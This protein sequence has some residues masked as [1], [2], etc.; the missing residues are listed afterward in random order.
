MIPRYSTR[1]A[2]TWQIV[3]G[4]YALFFGWK[5]SPGKDYGLT[6]GA[7]GHQNWEKSLHPTRWVIY[8]KGGNIGH[9]SPVPLPCGKYVNRKLWRPLLVK[10]TATCLNKYWVQASF[11][12]KKSVFPCSHLACIRLVAFFYRAKHSHDATIPLTASTR[13]HK[14]LRQW[15]THLDGQLILRQSH[16]QHAY[17]TF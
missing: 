14:S 6:S 8:D 15:K 16:L 13:V 12:C 7:L 2:T 5:G 17:V 3:Q 11:A 4:T 9:Y 10:N 1:R